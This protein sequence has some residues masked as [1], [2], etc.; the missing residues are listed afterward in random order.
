MTNEEYLD[1]ISTNLTTRE[2]L[3]QLAEESAELSQ[4]ALKTCRTLDDSNNPTRVDEDEAW[5]HLDE[6]LVDVLNAYCAVYGD[7][8]AAAS[9]LMDCAGSPKWQRWYERVKGAQQE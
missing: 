1:Y 7:F 6:E 8:S 3:E 4:A 5:R 9:A 2:L